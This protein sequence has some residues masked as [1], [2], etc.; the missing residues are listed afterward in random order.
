MEIYTCAV[1]QLYD[2]WAG[3][4]DDEDDFYNQEQDDANA[5]EVISLHRLLGRVAL[6]QGKLTGAEDELLEALQQVRLQL[7]TRHKET[8]AVLTALADVRDG[9]G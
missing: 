6:A 7:I 9:Q 8:M 3:S 5:V 1:V 4:G 2:D